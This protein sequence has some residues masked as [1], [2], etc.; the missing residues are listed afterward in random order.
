[1][2]NKLLLTGGTGFF[3]RS[4]LRHYLSNFEMFGS[5]I[6]VLSRNPQQ[7]QSDYPEF[8]SCSSVKYIKGDIQDRST[9]PWDYSFTHVLHAATDSTLGPSLNPLNRFQQIVDG[10]A[11]IL[12]LALAT[13]ATRFLLTSSGGIYGSQPADLEM[14]S[15]DSTDA[16]PL[17]KV[18]AVYSHAKRAA[19]HLCALYRQTY[20]LETVVARCFAFAGP[21]L[22]FNSHFA[23]S[24][25]IKDA[26]F[27]D[28]IMVA[29][30][31]TP[32]RTYLDQSDLANWLF[33]LMIEGV[34]GETYNVGS[35]RV[36]SIGELAHLVRDLLSSDKPVRIIGSPNS[37]SAR[38][39][40]VPSIDKIRLMHN[41]SPTFSLEQSIL[42][43][44]DAFRR[45]VY[46]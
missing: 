37:Y 35:D 38:N 23:I 40:Y 21:D 25:F 8:A 20:D 19:E 41:L 27:S 43:T 1:M 33:T 11:N 6:V 9:L 14:I 16:P 22:P 7:F 15:E 5:G 45:S 10:T 2:N 30:D 32:L 12:D 3:G 36:I 31:G 28:E 39:R 4:L 17:D 44:A 34:S 29:G 13:R 42:R 46:P 26:L 18:D 24:N